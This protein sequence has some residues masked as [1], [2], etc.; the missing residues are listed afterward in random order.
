MSADAAE[1]A[2]VAALRELLPATAAGI[3]LD[4]ATRGPLPTEAAEAM[5][6]AAE[7]DV[8]VG[9]VTPGR[10]EDIEQRAGEARAVLAAVLGASDPEAIVLTH[11]A[12]DAIELARSLLGT[13]LEAVPHVDPLTGGFESLE[14]ARLVDV[15]LTVG[16]V[17][18][19]VEDL[20]VEAVAFAA[21]RWLLGP[22]ATGALWLRDAALAGR[23]RQREFARPTLLGLARS[24]GWLA[25]YV[26]LPWMHERSARLAGRLSDRLARRDGVELASP[27]PPES[28][29]VSFRLPAWDVEEAADELNHRV[30]ALTRPF[31]EAGVIRASV[32]W[33]NTDDEIERFAEGVAELGR[34]NPQT[35]PRRPRLVVLPDR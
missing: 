25:M 8:R 16:A 14:G 7:W 27:A 31:A 9:R 5:R 34:H 19:A 17:P 28:G 23:V 12:E 26:G 6:D 24:V 2:R 33:F 4:T 35:L 3:Y 1:Q 20:A 21:D 30:Q 22:D 11:G 13:H 32:A 10:E 15:S 18:L 29:V